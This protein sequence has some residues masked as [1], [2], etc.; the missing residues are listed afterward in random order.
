MTPAIIKQYEDGLLKGYV[1]DPAADAELEKYLRE[2]DGYANAGDAIDDYSLRD[3]GKGRVSLPFLAALHFYPGCL[4]GGFQKRGSC[5]AWST[6][7]ALL[8]S[9]CAYIAY[10]ENPERFTIPTVSPVGIDN[11]VAST[12]GIYWFRGHGRDGWQCS[13]AAQ[14]A[15]ERC[16][17]LLRQNYP[18]INLDLTQYDVNLEAR[19]GISSPPEAV[20]SVCRRNLSSSATV[21]RGWEQ[22]RDMLAN[23]YALSSCGSEAFVSSRD[24]W[25]VCARDRSKTW[26]H[27]MAYIAADDRPEVHDR[28]GCGLVL[29]QNSWPISYLN[30]PDA[31]IGT[32]KRIPPGSFWARWTDCQNRYAV[33]FGPSKGWPANRMPDW[34]LGGI[35]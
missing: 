16:G 10:G 28:Y 22:V 27:A 11:G 5:V 12:E 9:Y 13:A 15:I 21:A 29:I 24:G 8:V 33:A 1:P 26:H 17:L 7:N 31:I 4:P 2:H 18:E 35:V 25:G 3:T 20:Q 34:G 19:W 32:G 23:G 30:G 6:R 14:V